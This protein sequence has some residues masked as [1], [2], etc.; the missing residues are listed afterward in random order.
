MS[1]YD[2]EY[3]QLAKIEG[4]ELI[5]TDKRLAKKLLA[6]GFDAVRLLGD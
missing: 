3:V 4:T 5:T 1:A 2:A 6:A